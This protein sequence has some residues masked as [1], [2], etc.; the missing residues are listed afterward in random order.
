M[1]SPDPDEP[2]LR[3]NIAKCTSKPFYLPEY[4]MSYQPN[5]A[6]MVDPSSSIA[7]LVEALEAWSVLSSNT[8]AAGVYAGGLLFEWID[9]Y[10]KGP[11]D[12]HMCS[13]NGRSAQPY[14]GAN[15]VRLADGC[16]CVDA[17]ARSPQ[18]GLDLRVPRPIIGLLGSIWTEYTPS[19]FNGSG[20]R[21]TP[22]PTS[23]DGAATPTP[24]AAHVTPAPTAAPS[25]DALAGP[26]EAALQWM[27]AGNCAQNAP[28]YA[29]RGLSDCNNKCSVV[30]YLSDKEGKCT[31][32]QVAVACS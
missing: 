5:G 13:P 29:A 3:A 6:R 17:A 14:Y 9:E 23:P 25:P 18:C 11:A 20:K 28:F 12:P 4:G 31:S 10:W 24:T 30:R 2:N 16:A 22:T 26:C 32:L 7:R 1:D 19:I 15:A 8:N 21:L 27:V